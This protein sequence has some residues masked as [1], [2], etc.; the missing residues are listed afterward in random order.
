MVL[1]LSYEELYRFHFQQRLC[2][3]PST[4]RGSFSST[5]GTLYS[6]QFSETRPSASS[7]LRSTLSGRYL[8]SLNSFSSR[9]GHNSTLGAQ[10]SDEYDNIVPR[11]GSGLSGLRNVGNSCYQNSVIQLLNA[12]PELVKCLHNSSGIQSTTGKLS[13]EM[14]RLFKEFWSTVEGEIINPMRFRSRLFHIDKKWMGDMQEDAH[15]FLTQIVSALQEDYNRNIGKPKYVE[16]EDQ[17]DVKVQAMMEWK[18]S[19]QWN[20]SEI[21]DI[22]SF[23]LHNEVVCPECGHISHR[24][25]YLTSLEV[26]LPEQASSIEDCLIEFMKAERLDQENEWYC[27]KCKTHVQATKQ[28]RISRLPK[29]LILCF[30]RFSSSTTFNSFFHSW[31]NKVNIKIPEEHVSLKSV[32]SSTVDA[33]RG[34]MTDYELIG[35]VDHSGSVNF[36]HYTAR[37]KNIKNKNWY[38]MNDEN[39]RRIAKPVGPSQSAY[40][41]ALRQLDAV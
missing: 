22:F 14:T 38:L 11:R 26:P 34:F 25:E 16:M 15:E 13:P 8:S 19:K 3:S 41:L 24:F 36:G 33:N 28:L 6:S 2:R 39:V 27:S 5:R 23:Q 29:V 30:K 20:D 7:S 1:C 32:L 4:R 37:V 12:I 10:S 31:K 17:N 21:D 9:S 40:I 18:Y 35:I